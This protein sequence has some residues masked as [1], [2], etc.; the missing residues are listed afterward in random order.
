MKILNLIFE[1]F[2]AEILVFMEF[3]FLKKQNLSFIKLVAML[4]IADFFR[5]F[6][7]S[8]YKFIYFYGF[9]K[10]FYNNKKVFYNNKI[11]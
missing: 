6:F 2:K 11:L 3:I 4:V 7:F 5:L 1:I 9:K 10:I 8:F